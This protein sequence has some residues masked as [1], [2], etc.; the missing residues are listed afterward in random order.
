[1]MQP[2]GLFT[3]RDGEQMLVHECRGCGLVRHNRIAADDNVVAMM[4]LPVVD[5][6]SGDEVEEVEART[7]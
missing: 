6:G 7:A 4:R 5:T 1:M 3:R 2:I